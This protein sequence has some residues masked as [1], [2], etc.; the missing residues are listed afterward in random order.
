MPSSETSS[1]RHNV[2]PAPTALPSFAQ[3][4][5]A[6]VPSVPASSPGVPPPPSSS[7]LGT[8]PFSVRAVGGQ[9]LNTVVHSSPHVTPPSPAYASSPPASAG[10]FFPPQPQHVQQHRSSF[11]PSEASLDIPFDVTSGQPCDPMTSHD[12][13]PSTGVLNWFTKTISQSEF[14][15][16]VAER[17]KV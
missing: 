14:L 15:T 3:M 12:R 4:P 16:K 1:N 2:P 6:G 5:P 8:N 17:A 9:S 13:R 10:A 11:P 7:A